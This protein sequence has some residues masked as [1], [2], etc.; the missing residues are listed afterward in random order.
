MKH[1]TD[2]HRRQHARGEKESGPDHSD[3]GQGLTPCPAAGL[4][5]EHRIELANRPLRDVGSHFHGPGGNDGGDK[6]GNDDCI[7]DGSQVHLLISFEHVDHR[8][9]RPRRHAGDHGH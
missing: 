9:Y 6:A 8:P 5:T 2:D 7:S 1:Q 4:T 3:W